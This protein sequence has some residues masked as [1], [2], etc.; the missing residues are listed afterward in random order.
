MT[1][2]NTPAQI[3]LSFSR[4]AG[5]VAVAAGEKYPWARTALEATGFQRRQDGTYSLPVEDPQAAQATMAELLRTADRHLSVVKISGRTFI[6]DV[7]EGIAAHL[8]GRWSATVDV[9][10]HPVWQEDLV[11][12]LWD[13]GE[14]A[15]EV[16]TA[17]IPCAAVLNDGAGTELLLIERPGHR[18]D[19]LVGAFA[20]EGFDDNYEDPHAPSSIVIP[21]VAQPAA[22]A[23]S[24][25]FLPAYQQA[26]RARRVADIASTLERLREEYQTWE[27]IKASGRYSDGSPLM[28][29][30]LPG[31]EE[32]FANLSWNAFGDT[33]RH[34]L[35]VLERCPPAGPVAPQDAAALDRLAGAL[36]R[37][38]EVIA[39]WD[40][41]QEDWRRTPRAL[42]ADSYIDAKAERDA[43]L[44][45]VIETWLADGDAFLRHA[46]AVTP[47]P[48]SGPSGQGRALPALPPAVP[49]PPGS[50][51]ARR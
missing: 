37:G 10:S 14:L 35:A 7:A 44:R 1:S 38:E 16:R 27:M 47:A 23:I 29:G 17:R 3:T 15:Q 8:P 5:I 39:D 11:P 51:P 32:A 43:R 21:G 19:Y 48:P 2:T 40:A 22:Q 25:R 4:S 6:G 50:A 30:V 26:V 41:L 45:P 13:T 20:P 33:L 12:L 34:G 9:Y 18:Q 46:R 36:A 28:A 24:E 31:A 49:A 42:T